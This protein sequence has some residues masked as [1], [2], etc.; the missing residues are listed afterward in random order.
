[1]KATD[2]I[3]L[4]APCGAHCGDCW[5]YKLKDDPSSCENLIAMNTMNIYWS[6]A[7]CPG[8]RPSGGNCQFINGVC[9][10]YT[11]IEK[12]GLV[13]CFECVEFPCDKL[14]PAA[15]MADILPHNIK[16]FNLC[17][18]KQHG[19]AKWLRKAAEINAKYFHGKMRIGRGPQLD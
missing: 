13:F 15:E 12:R 16:I 7:P 17:C 19:V 3:I 18:I 2:E 10:T 9:E 8:C 11:C 14:N 6:G 4:V 5:A 1:M